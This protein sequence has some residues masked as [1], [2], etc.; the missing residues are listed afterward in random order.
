MHLTGKQMAENIN[1]ERV[2]A[3]L[4][5]MGTDLLSV[6]ANSCAHAS[7]PLSKSVSACAF[8][9]WHYMHC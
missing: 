4:Q 6:C 9:S 1:K 7:V 3:K 8:I 5:K 2:Q